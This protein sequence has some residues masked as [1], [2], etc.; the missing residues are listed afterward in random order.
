ME[1]KTKRKNRLALVFERVCEVCVFSCQCLIS[2]TFFLDCVTDRG[3]RSAG[4]FVQYGHINTRTFL[5]THTVAVV[6]VFVWGSCRRSSQCDWYFS[7]T[8]ERKKKKLIIL[9]W[10]AVNN[11]D[12]LSSTSTLL[13]LTEHPTPFRGSFSTTKQNTELD[14][15]FSF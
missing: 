13:V 3:Y 10:F 12:I 15:F 5:H 11:T 7:N 4:R 8:R 2:D 1:G 14:F 6:P 9:L